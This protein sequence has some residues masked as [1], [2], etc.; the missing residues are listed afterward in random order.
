M[1]ISKEFISK[2]REAML[3]ARENYGGSDAKYASTLGIGGPIYSRIKKGETEKVLSNPQWLT[4]GKKLNV[5]LRE[6]KWKS[7]RTSVYKEVDSSL[8]FCQEF[9]K[10]MILVDDCGIGKTYCAKNVVGLLKNAFYVDCSQSKTSSEFVRSLARIIGV[11]DRGKINAIK[12][13][14][15]YCLNTLENPLVVMDEAGDL[16]TNAYLTLKELWNATEK[17]CGWYMIGAEGLQHKIEKAINRKAVG[18][19]ELFSRFSGDFIKI[20][21]TIKSDRE[22]FYKKL[23]GDV[24]SVNENSQ[25]E[26]MRYIKSCV[27]DKKDLRY[28]ETLVRVNQTASN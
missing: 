22:D 3:S 16:N 24:A 28:L 23:V 26:V 15:K 6:N 7:A 19:A 4:I 9:S 17:S 10:S 25:Q 27:G 5:T 21:P 18:F 11:D 1:E 8:R 20:V 2:V 12:S 13:D 14:V